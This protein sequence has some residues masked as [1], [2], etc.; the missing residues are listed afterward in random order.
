MITAV[1]ILV[2]C[3]I[4]VTIGAFTFWGNPEAINPNAISFF[5]QLLEFF[6][7]WGTGG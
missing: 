6:N 1:S 4:V 3:V 2:V 5:D 7:D